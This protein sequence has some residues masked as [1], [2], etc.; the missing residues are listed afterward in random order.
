M[1]DWKSRIRNKYFV[2]AFVSFIVVAIKVFTGYKFPENTDYLVNSLLSA[3]L[4]LG[5]LVDPS[6]PGLGD[7]QVTIPASATTEDVSNQIA[8]ETMDTK[9]G[10]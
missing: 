10:E 2:A 5:I 9:D 8:P 6:T 4:G 1:I 3:L 7:A